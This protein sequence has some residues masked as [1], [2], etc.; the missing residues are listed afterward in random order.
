MNNINDQK[1]INVDL[2][3]LLVLYKHYKEFLLP[4]GVILVS[5]LVIVYVVFPQIQQYFSSRNLVKVEQQK[6]D[7]LKNNYTLLTS[8]D[9]AKITA[10]L[11]TLSLALPA[12]KDFAGIIDAISYVSAK[13]GVA[14]GNFEFSL[15]NLSASNFAGTAYPST[16]ID[17][18]LKGNTKNIAQ[19][20]HE[21]TRTM[22]IAEVTTINITGN[23]GSLTILFYYKPFPAQNVSDETQIIPLSVKQTSLIKEVS[24]WNSITQIDLP[25]LPAIPATSSAGSSGSPF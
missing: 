18:S 10:D 21:I 13:T 5:I 12:Q 23:S 16:K 6:L 2:E 17:I 25:T 19:F 7:K 20:A 1:K 8:L 14:V 4:V 22:P 15:G 9:D 3:N 24:S 11:N